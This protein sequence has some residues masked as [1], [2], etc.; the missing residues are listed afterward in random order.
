M[1]A[2]T[3]A[4]EGISLVWWPTLLQH[5]PAPEIEAGAEETIGD[6]TDSFT[7]TL[8]NLANALRLAEVGDLEEITLP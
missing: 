7:T 1:N 6:D 3:S 8:H 2:L 5:L 4:L